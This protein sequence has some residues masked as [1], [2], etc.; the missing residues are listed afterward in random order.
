MM[1]MVLHGLS[2]YSLL[3]KKTMENETRFSDLLGTMMNFSTGEDT[4]EEEI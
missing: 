3:S 1:E 4:E 2:A